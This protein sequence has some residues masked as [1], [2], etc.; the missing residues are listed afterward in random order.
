VRDA[1][2]EGLHPSKIVA[3]HLN[4]RSRAA[5]RGRVPDVPSY[6]LKPPSSLS[7]TGRQIVR[8]AGARLLA[9]EGEIAVVVGRT[10]RDVRPAEALAHVAGYAPANDV[11]V[12]DLRDCDRG[13]NLRAKGQ[14]GYTPVGRV[15]PAG[16]IDPASLVL[17]TF[18]NGEVVQDTTGD[19]LLF[20]AADVVADLSR[21]S[22]LEAGDLIL[23]GTPAG[24]GI[25]G[26]GDVVEVELTAP[27]GV[28][29][30]VTNAVAEAQAPLAPFGA[31]PQASPELE[32]LATGK[33][34][35]RNVPLEPRTARRLASVSTATLS[36]QLR[37]RGIDHHAIGGV[38][39]G[40][41]QRRMVGFARTLRYV[42]LRE[43]VFRR[44]GG[45]ANAQKAAVETLQP[46][47]VLVVEARGQEGAGTI[48]DI[49][50]LAAQVR[51]A[52]G[53]VTDGGVRDAAAVARLDIPTYAAFAHPA[54][55]GR[56][57]V[58][59][60]TDV[61]IACGGCLVL[62][63]DVVVGD[64]DGVVVVPRDLVD[65]VA[66]DAEKQERQ[67]AFIAERVAA[68]ESLFG[69]YPMDDERKA[70]YARWAAAR[71]PAG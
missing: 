12:W 71:P 59:L 21:T 63:G 29:S 10:A 66:A 3:V 13:S 23:L 18:V 50:V 62:P 47:E 41:P 49:L 5:Q 7:W 4:Y 35:P 11:G 9:Y 51:G 15:L 24:T 2:P 26:P 22:T 36:S 25:L 57:H 19:A 32:A 58:P 61:A 56:R 55:L 39:S 8:P 53:V 54:V 14:D 65:D 31:M 37:R 69:L 48:G 44:L 16:E 42:P 38:T 6:F 60:E 67:E 27:G 40:S 28:S 34:V 64:A 30:R 20:D 1:H 33:P 68:G 43:D 70:Q 46:G 45:A 52:T 17:R